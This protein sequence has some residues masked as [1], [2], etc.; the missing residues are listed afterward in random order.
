MFAGKTLLITGGT[1][2][3]GN[4]VLKRF[5]GRR[6]C[7]HQDPFARREETGRNAQ[8]VCEFQSSGSLLVTCGTTVR[9]G[10]R[11]SVWTTCFTPPLSSRCP[12]CEFFPIEAV[13]T[14]IIGSDNVI[15]ACIAAGVKRAIFS[16]HRQGRVPHQRDGNEQGD[17]GEERHRA[18]PEHNRDRRGLSSASPATATSW[19]RADRSS[20]SSPTR[21]TGVLPITI[22]DPEMTRFLMTLD[23]A[24]DLVLYAFEHGS[25][26]DLFIQKGTGLHD[27]RPRRR[28]HGSTW[29]RPPRRRSSERVTGKSSLRLS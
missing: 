20:P 28:D 25:Q 13:K 8:E 14:N 26:G 15:S 24:V 18:E 1:G 22:T 23:D 3:F 17:H 10:T 5:L 12:S 29:A 2:S 6:P 21:S 9:S 27:R 4:A 7:R 19:P 11:S 16:E